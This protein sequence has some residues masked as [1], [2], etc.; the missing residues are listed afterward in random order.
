MDGIIGLVL[1]ILVAFIGFLIWLAAKA[2]TLS[3]ATEDLRRRADR[4]EAELRH[5]QKAQAAPAEPTAPAPEPLAE[6]LLQERRRREAQPP[7]PLPVM[8]PEPVI[9]PEPAIPQPVFPEPI[10]PEAPPV[11]AETAAAAP[12]PAPIA[13]PA[14]PSL[15]SIDWEQFMGVK[16]FAWIGGFA[17]FLGIAFFVKYSFDNNLISPQLRVALSFLTGLGLV[18]GGTALKRK[19]YVV[20]SQTLCATGIVILYATTFAAHAYYH[21]PFFGQIPTFLLMTLITATAFLLAVRMEAQVVAVL[22][23]LGGFLT[24][25]LLGSNVDNPLG[26]F[27][28]I[29]LL[30]LGLIA[31][32][33]H[34]RWDYLVLLGALGTIAMQFGWVEKFFETSKVYTAMAVFLGFSALFVATFGTAT[35]RRQFNGWLAAATLAVSFVALGFP[36]YLLTLPTVSQHPPHMARAWRVAWTSSPP[37][38]RRPRSTRAKRRFTE[39]RPNATCTRMVRRRAAH[40]SQAARA[41][42]PERR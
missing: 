36:F 38:S 42:S 29:A 4:L 10:T 3:S 16:L 17:L 34:R 11:M 37:V 19:A 18:F 33:L 39:V 31:V 6:T 2:V 1:L 23:L 15:P 26:L 13:P 5:L 40:S 32:A 41:T 25:V 30:D 20:T 9:P 28:Y 12:T 22:G 14:R 7:P 35:R 21:F 8:P 27:G 24:P